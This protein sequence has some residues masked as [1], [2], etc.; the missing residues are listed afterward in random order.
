[1]II[2]Y[3]R[4]NDNRCRDIINVMIIMIQR[5]IINV[6]LLIIIIIIYTVNYEY[7]MSESISKIIKNTSFNPAIFCGCSDEIRCLEITF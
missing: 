3:I 1:M 7:A 6:I 5:D 4:Y 2:R